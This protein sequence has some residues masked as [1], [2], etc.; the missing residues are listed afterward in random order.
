MPARKTAAKKKTAT[1]TLTTQQAQR[2]DLADKALDLKKKGYSYREIGNKLKIGTS[3][4]HKYIAQELTK[5]AE[6]TQEKTMEYRQLQI[7]R[8]E[9]LLRVSME[10]ATTGDLNAIDKARR[11]IDSLSQVTGA[12]APTKIAA[13]TPDGEE[14]APGGI[15]VV[16]AVAGSVDE[17]LQQYAPKSN[18]P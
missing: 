12:N 11:I 6:M 8:L 15:I 13:T 9:K 18:N 16:P 1:K 3:T 4:A 17:W 2:A 5:L 10:L 7:E 14:A